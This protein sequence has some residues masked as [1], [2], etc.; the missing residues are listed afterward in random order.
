MLN[1]SDLILISERLL[2]IH[3]SAALP[4][5]FIGAMATCRRAAGAL[6]MPCPP[7]WPVRY[8]LLVQERLDIQR[9]KHDAFLAG[10][11]FIICSIV[12]IKKFKDEA[13]LV[14]IKFK[15]YIIG[16]HASSQH[17][18]HS[19]QWKCVL[20]I[21]SGGAGDDPTV[22]APQCIQIKQGKQQ[23]K[24]PSEHPS[25]ACRSAAFL[26]EPNRH[27]RNLVSTSW[28]FPSIHPTSRARK[29][30]SNTDIPDA[31]GILCRSLPAGPAGTQCQSVQTKSN[32]NPLMSGMP[33]SVKRCSRS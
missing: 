32:C 24:R 4:C 30:I 3:S 6:A 33:C 23:T 22:L 10:G 31:C 27:R 19:I 26:R 14:F 15:R 29:E 25:S 2:H 28:A 13:E 18:I 21:Q 17:Q 7:Q 5:A 9:P 12:S 11:K 8:S 1:L 16:R 20:R